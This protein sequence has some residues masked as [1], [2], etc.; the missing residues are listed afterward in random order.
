[1]TKGKIFLVPFP[2]DDLSATK[3]RPALCLTNPIGTR[4][5]VLL[6]YI[7]S[8]IPSNLLQTDIVLDTTHPDFAAT[9][10]RQPSTIRLHQLATVST[11]V[12]QRKLGELSSDTQA[13]ITEKLYKWLRD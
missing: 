7:T 4:R 2:Y 8:R 3:V 1:M 5:H 11:V 9:G 12:I 13:R 6:A 10:L